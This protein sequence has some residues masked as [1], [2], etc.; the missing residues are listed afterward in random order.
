[1]C[2]ERTKEGKREI[3]LRGGGGKGLRGKREKE[4]KRK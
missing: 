1:L 4:R 3:K 2:K